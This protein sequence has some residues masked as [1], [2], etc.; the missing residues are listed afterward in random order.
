MNSDREIFDFCN[1]AIF[2]D[3]NNPE[4]IEEFNMIRKYIIYRFHEIIPINRIV[5][6]L[7]IIDVMIL[8]IF[9][10]EIDNILDNLHDIRENIIYMISFEKTVRDDK[11]ILSDLDEDD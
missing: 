8:K 1:R 4:Y 7:S 9:N 11:E 3:Y 2:F 10:G 5:F 6:V